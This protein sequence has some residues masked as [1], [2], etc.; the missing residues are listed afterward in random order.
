MHSRLT[1]STYDAMADNTGE[2]TSR[3]SL[4]DLAGSERVWRTGAEGD[5]LRE[6]GSINKSLSSTYAR[7]QTVGRNS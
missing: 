6:G 3:I 7:W 4:V 1:E 2:K 5:R